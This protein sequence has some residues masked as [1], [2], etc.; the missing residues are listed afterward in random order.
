MLR[1]EKRGD[2]RK[3][4]YSSTRGGVM[5][6]RKGGSLSEVEIRDTTSNAMMF[7]AFAKDFS[8]TERGREKR[9]WRKK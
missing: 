5:K 6:Y 3:G 8:T 1:K 9:N 4:N 2:V 7:V